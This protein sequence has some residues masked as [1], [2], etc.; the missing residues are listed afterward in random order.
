[1]IAGKRQT[2]KKGDTSRS[3]VMRSMAR[4]AEGAPAPAERSA[5][6][7]VA[8]A[9]RR[10]ILRRSE[11]DSFIGRE[12]ELIARY[13][14]SKPTFRQAAKMLEH[15][16]ILLIKRGAR[17]GFF[18]RPPT[19]KMVSHMA[20]MV[21]AARGATLKQIGEVAGPLTVEAVREVASNPNLAV[22]GRLLAFVAENEGFEKLPAWERGKVI[23][24][25]ERLVA[26][27][28]GNPA[29]AL[30]SEAIRALVRDPIF[31]S[32]RLSKA[33][34]AEVAASYRSLAELIGKGET[35]MAVILARR[36]ASMVVDWL[37]DQ[38]P[39]YTT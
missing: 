26:H 6:Q 35:E 37:P 15:E 1:V 18:A 36:Y 28:S 19:E 16:Q 8:D 23:A 22:R 4:S 2:P 25:F 21:L 12:D 7:S 27:L 13:K 9:L 17:G 29:L 10:E 32:F 5:T 24:D 14:V 30:F 38:I 34:A 20:A 33:Q 3:R 11:K 39:T 31:S